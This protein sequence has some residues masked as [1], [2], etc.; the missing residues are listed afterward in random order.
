MN[1]GAF[2]REAAALPVREVGALI[3][4]GG[5]VVVAPHPDDESLGC[6]G[7]IAEARARGVGVRLVVLSDGVGSHRASKAYPPARLKALREAETIEAAATLGLARGHIR[8]LGL[9]DAA[10]PIEGAAAAQAIAA[11]EAAL[12]DCGADTL[13]VTWR[14]D[15][16]CDHRA[17]AGLVEIVRARNKDLRAFAY[18][19]W[20]W[21]LPP[22]LDVGNPPRGMR[23]DVSR[24]K[25]VK[26]EAVFAHRSQTSALIDDDPDGFRLEPAMIERFLGPYEIFLEMEAAR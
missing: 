14:H 25:A 5:L 20:G 24:H 9:P 19:I 21:T 17:A 2:L 13:C 11:I 15:P 10:V 7:L 3:G 16:H 18:P 22:D 4:D 1:A 23:I 12:E 6:G 26:R 8:F